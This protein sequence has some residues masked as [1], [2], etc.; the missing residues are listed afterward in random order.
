VEGIGCC[1]QWG[2]GD[3]LK[4]N[5]TLLGQLVLLQVVLTPRPVRAGRE[6]DLYKYGRD[7]LSF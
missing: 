7:R 2:W 1:S 4:D 3:L 5:V 6:T